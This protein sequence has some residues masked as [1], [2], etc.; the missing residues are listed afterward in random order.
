MI[1]LSADLK[2]A[3]PEGGPWIIWV[4]LVSS[5]EPLTAETEGNHQTQSTGRIRCGPQG[6]ETDL[7]PAAPG[8][9]SCGTEGAW[10]WVHHQSQAAGTGAP[11]VLCV[12]PWGPPAPTP[13]S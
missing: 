4:E 8:T 5:R 10:K 3:A 2:G 7:H 12:S 13:Q 6:E 1:Y 9:G 11:G